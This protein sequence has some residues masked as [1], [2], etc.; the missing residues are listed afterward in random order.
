LVAQINHRL[1]HNVQLQASYTWSHALDYGENN[2]TFSN[3]NSLVDPQNLRAEYGNSVQNVP[4]RFI[5]TA[6]TTSPWHATG[7][8]SY[9]VNGYQLSP[10]LS[11]QNGEP[12]SAT[13]NGNPQNLASPTSVTGYITG[14]SSGF[15]GSGG[16]TRI[17]VL[18]RNTFQLPKTVLLDLRGSKRFAI[19]ERYN[20]EFLAEAFNL[21]NHQNI[22]ATNTP[23]YAFGTASTGGTTVST[24]T[25]YTGAAF[26]SVS[27][28]NNNNIYTPRQIQLGVRLQF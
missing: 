25:Q 15:T 20:L 9:L 21:P 17:P 22:T 2:T 8:K 1:D 4:N 19:R 3:T 18:G 12:Y 24:L 16:G 10:S 26:G 14:I 11:A 28:S 6:I 5:L 13:L 23:A 27:N 7:W